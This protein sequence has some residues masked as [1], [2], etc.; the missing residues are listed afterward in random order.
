MDDLKLFTKN[1]YELEQDLLGT[2]VHEIGHALGFYHEQ[3]KPTRDLSVTILFGNIIAG[4]EHNFVAAAPA[5][6]LEPGL[7]YD[8]RSVMHYGQYAF[9]SNGQITINAHIDRDLLLQRIG[10][11]DGLSFHDIKLANI[12]YCD[13]VCAGIMNNCER[14]IQNPNDCTRCICPDDF[15]WQFCENVLPPTGSRCS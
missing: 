6:V 3:A 12:V 11:R 13:G 15:T 4:T 8:Y 7:P 2:V 14:G 1:D 5:D 9:S 10:Q